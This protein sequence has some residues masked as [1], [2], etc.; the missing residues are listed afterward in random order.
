MNLSFQKICKC[1]C[2][3][4]VCMMLIS[5][6]TRTKVVRVEDNKD[7]ETEKI[8]EEIL[9]LDDS[10]PAGRII[11]EAS[12]WLGTPYKYACDQKGVGTDCSG[13]VMQ[14]FLTTAAIKLPRNASKQAEFCTEIDVKKIDTGDLVFFATGSD[15]TRVS[16]V[17]IMI[18]SDRFIH[19][20]TS[21]GV[22]VS[23]MSSPYYTK[24][25]LLFGRVPGLR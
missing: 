6:H 18:D 16:H 7:R 8:R 15:S 25:F 11:A 12:S 1:A 19:A 3:L 24:H 21:K 10:T 17:G 20:S 14:I 23:Y 4:S 22:V 2:L 5:C 9:N 13:M